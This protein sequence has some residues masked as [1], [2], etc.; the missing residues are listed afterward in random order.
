VSLLAEP[1]VV[2]LGLFRFVRK[3]NVGAELVEDVLKPPNAANG[4]FV[5]PLWEEKTKDDFNIQLLP[6][7]I[8]LISM[9]TNGLIKCN[10]KTWSNFGLIY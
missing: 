2:S 8:V 9:T 3:L 5:A 1:L 4:F 7:R 6:R 10:T